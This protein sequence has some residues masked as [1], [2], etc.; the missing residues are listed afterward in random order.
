MNNKI[1]KLLGLSLN[2]E[3]YEQ[4]KLHPGSEWGCFLE[5][6]SLIT[7]VE[8]NF[9]LFNIDVIGIFQNEDDFEKIISANNKNHE[10][11]HE[12]VYKKFI[13]VPCAF[14]LKTQCYNKNYSYYEINDFDMIEK[15][16]ECF[17][18]FEYITW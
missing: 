13:L 10:W 9:N 15:V 17:P 6:D 18:G 16:E 14:G 7:N 5:T 11:I 4:W 12:N 2:K 1:Y 3:G 8:C